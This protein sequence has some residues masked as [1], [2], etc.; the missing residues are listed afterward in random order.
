MGNRSGGEAPSMKAFSF[1]LMSWSIGTDANF[2][3][4]WRRR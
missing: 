3:S 4:R 1:W 2:G